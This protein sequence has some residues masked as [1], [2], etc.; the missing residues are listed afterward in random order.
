MSDPSFETAGSSSA[1][2]SDEAQTV[3]RPD[4]LRR[5]LIGVGASVALV[6][7]LVGVAGAL[8]IRRYDHAVIRDSLI[9]PGARMPETST[10][11]PLNLL[12]IGSDFRSWNPDAGQRSD[13]IILAHV[14]RTM[15]RVFLISVP[16]D[17]LVTIPSMPSIGFGGDTT[18]INAAFDYGRGG[19]GGTQLVSA[20]LTDLVGVRFDGAAVIDFP[21]LRQAVDI[22]GGV[23]L[24]LDDRIVSANT[25]KVFL[26]GC[27]LMQST[28]VL[29]YLRQRDFPDGD[30]TR[31]R[32]QQ[33]FLKAFLDRAR[34]TGAAANPVKTDALIRAVAG[35]MTVDTGDTPL[36]DL[37]FALRD[38]SAEGVTGIKIP[39]SSDMI[40]DV[41]YVVASQDAQGLFDAI[42][43]DSVERWAHNNADWVNKI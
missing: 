11:G 10:G 4:R 15:D 7:A 13:T 21:G 31:Q 32:H 1:D 30:F 14:P 42:R 29:D 22:L 23:R 25:G 5:T 28:D 27:Q 34:S 16:R 3:H 2:P 38:L 8:L 19:A 43:F 18:K 41:S 36:S 33:Q 17:L 26:P 37:V 9:A 6:L 39:S 20:T 12:L 35:T 40:D 24:C